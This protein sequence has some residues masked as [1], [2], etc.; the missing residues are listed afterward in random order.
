MG[1]QVSIPPVS[2]YLGKRWCLAPNLVMLQEQDIQRTPPPSI[3]SYSLGISLL[4]GLC[5]SCLIAGRQG[6]K[7]GMQL[8][9]SRNIILVVPTSTW[10]VVLAETAREKRSNIPEVSYNYF[11][12]GCWEREEGVGSK[13]FSPFFMSSKHSLNKQP[14]VFILQS[15]WMSLCNR[16]I[17]HSISPHIS[18][19]GIQYSHCSFSCLLQTSNSLCINPSEQLLFHFTLGDIKLKYSSA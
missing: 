14:A 10:P 18:N 8:L 4:T 7:V 17:H 11:Y 12:D 5:Y 13:F 6:E 1:K 16:R 15:R 3:V 19:A 9:G 2:G